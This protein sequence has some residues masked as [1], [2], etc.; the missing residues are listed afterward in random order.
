MTQGHVEQCSKVEKGLFY[1]RRQ[2]E[3]QSEHQVKLKA[4]RAITASEELNNIRD[5]IALH[6]VKVPSPKKNKSR[7]R[8]CAVSVVYSN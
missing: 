2:D 6:Q 3:K 7:R 5:N 1:G 8:L 4:F